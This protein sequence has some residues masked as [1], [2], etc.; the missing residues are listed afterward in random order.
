METGEVEWFILYYY[1]F[2]KFFSQL[3]ETKQ[4]KII[5][6]NRKPLKVVQPNSSYTLLS[7]AQW[8]SSWATTDFKLLIWKKQHDISCRNTQVIWRAVKICWYSWSKY[9]RTVRLLLWLCFSKSH[10]PSDL[11]RPDSPTSSSITRYQHA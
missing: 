3:E 9:S 5:S 8:Y 4:Q 7:R 11:V 2:S 6:K 10:L 1:M